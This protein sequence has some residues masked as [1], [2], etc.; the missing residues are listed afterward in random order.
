MNVRS[1]ARRWLAGI[2]FALVLTLLLAGLRRLAA[3]SVAL[4][5]RDVADQRLAL[6]EGKLPLWHWQLRQRR[7]IVAGRA[8]GAAD[9]AP[10]DG[11]TARRIGAGAAT[12]APG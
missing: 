8:F 7:G 9:V 1:A 11:G 12:G 5:V 6:I 10:D 4:H 3:D 2:G